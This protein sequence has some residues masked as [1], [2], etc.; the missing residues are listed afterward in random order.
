MTDLTDL[1]RAKV[2]LAL[3]VVGRRGDGYHL[4]DM[5]VAFPAVGDR[6]SLAPADGFSLSV[7]G[8]NA[9]ALAGLPAADNLVLR[10][11]DRLA[12]ALRNDG[13]ETPGAG[14]T[15]EKLLPVM[16]GIG[17]GSANAAA[18][19]RLLARHW[20]IAADDPRVVATA[21]ALGADVPMCLLS[22]PL[23]AEGVGEILTPTNL[24]GSAGILLVNP[25]VGVATP[26][27][28]GA[29][30]NRENAPLPTF[31]S[32]TFETLVDY[33]GAT[34]NDL[35][36]PATRLV[37]AIRDVLDLLGTLPGAAIARMSGSGSTCFALFPDEASAQS[38]EV[39]VGTARPHWWT[40]STSLS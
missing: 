25:G 2:N 7:S 38:A 31:A 39:L 33:L 18:A 6:L 11:A 32:G 13:I 4:L 15:L 3:H 26:A 37:P 8:P 20:T 17:G 10:A 9:A 34:R 27:V 22:R 24:P 30:K 23:R 14:F 19:L 28:F 29:L 5:L 36:E 12:A 16:G 35:E 40:A 21:A 1:A